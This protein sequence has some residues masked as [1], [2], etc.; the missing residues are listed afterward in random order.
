MDL[1][2]ALAQREK[3]EVVKALEA[4]QGNAGRA[5]KRLGIS[6]ANLYLRLTKF[7]LRIRD[8]VTVYTPHAERIAQM[9]TH[10]VVCARCGRSCFHRGT[11]TLHQR[12]CQGG[13]T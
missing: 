5:A 6:R 11:L 12:A 13:V 1:K 2:A 4:E 10:P 7:K 3:M 8:V 9:R